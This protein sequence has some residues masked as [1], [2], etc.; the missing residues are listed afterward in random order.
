[1]SRGDG[2]YRVGRTW[3]MNYETPDGVRHR[4]TTGK[5]DYQEAKD[6][7]ARTVGDVASGRPVISTARVTFEYGCELI[8]TDYRVKG[9]RSIG[10]LETTLKRLG[11][12]F[13]P[14]RP[15]ASIGWSDAL[16]YR[17]WRESK[18]LARATINKHLAALKHLLR[19]AVR[20]GKLLA[21]PLIEIPDPKNARQGF[22]EQED[23]DAVLEHLPANY[24]AVARFAYYTGWRT[25]SEVLPLR[26]S[27]VNGGVARLEPGTTK[28][29]EGRSFPFDVL[30]PFAQLMDE[31]RARKQGP[32]LFHEAG[33]PIAYHRWLE[34]W[35]KAC[36]AAE[37]RKI[38]HDLRRTAV[39]NLERAGVARS[40]AMQL[41]GH[42]T[43]AVYARYAIVAEQDLRDGV[44]KLSRV[45]LTSQGT[46]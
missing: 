12:Y 33:Q 17:V 3:Y 46:E 31:L 1:M 42:K 32:Y 4:V 29:S 22:F 5:R 15:L 40:V 21:V 10:T 2:L 43:A 35:H 28:N 14:S 45:T 20:D 34:A 19:L 41:T 37:C 11:E 44:A 16:Q 9:R 13:A 39:R 26:W 36:A 18:G 24:A 25:H 30:P 7:R 38:P 23:F 8:R 6:V 27:Q